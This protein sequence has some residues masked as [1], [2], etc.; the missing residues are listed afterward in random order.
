MLDEMPTSG[1]LEALPSLLTADLPATLGGVLRVLGQRGV[2][3]VTARPAALAADARV[4][5]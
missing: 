5:G 3:T 2:V 1:L 4:Q